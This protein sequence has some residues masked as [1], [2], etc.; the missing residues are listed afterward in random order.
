V[1]RAELAERR[2]RARDVDV[3]DSDRHIDVE[4]RAC[5]TVRL[6][7]HAADQHERDVVA[8]ER[9]K[10]RVGTCVDAHPVNAIG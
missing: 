3:V 5:P 9:G 7:A 8:R 2:V 6:A 4:G 1:A 10:D